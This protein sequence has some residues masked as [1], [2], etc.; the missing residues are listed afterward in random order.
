MSKID[1]KYFNQLKQN[2]HSFQEKR[3]EII[4]ASN[5]ALHH[6]K[7]IIFALH[8]DEF[9]EAAR[10]IKPTC[11]FLMRARLKRQPKNM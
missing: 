7:R 5:N 10:S 3:I 8:R 4:Q 6:A 9:K 1:Q 11:M 2:L